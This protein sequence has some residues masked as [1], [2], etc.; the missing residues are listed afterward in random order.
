LN[1]DPNDARGYALKA[2]ALVFAGSS[3]AAIPVALAG[4]DIGGY[5]AQLHASL[6]RAYA[7]TGR[8][9]DAVDEGF[10][11]VS[12]DPADVD[13]RRSYAYALSWVS[14]NDEAIIQ[15]ETAL[16]IDSN[17]IP[18]Y[19]ELAV[20]Y[21]AQNRDQDAINLY[22]HVLALQPRNP[23]AFLR[24]CETYRKIGQF[25]RAIGFCEDAIAEDSTL[26]PAFYQLGILKYNL[27]DFNGALNAF[28]Q[29]A[30]LDP[31]SLECTYRLGLSYYYVNDCDMA[32]QILQESLLMAQ[33]RI[34]VEAAIENIR[35]GLIAIGQKC[36]QYGSVAPTATP[37]PTIEV[38]TNDA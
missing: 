22:D 24:L 33:S 29:C 19:F 15:L 23:R 1:I 30:E 35:E 26:V 5:S 32:W 2:R 4:L 9:E 16:T 37:E 34:G 3:T 18:V 20:Q 10:Q 36:P 12:D 14:A 6:A 38:D 27:F 17:Q 11:A 8:Y 13:A 21:L 7:D 28:S 25:E 31:S